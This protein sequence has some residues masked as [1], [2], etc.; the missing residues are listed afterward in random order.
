MP[1]IPRSYLP[2]AQFRPEKIYPLPEVRLP[3]RLN[4]ASLFL[5][6]HIVEGRGGKTAVIYRDKRGNDRALSFEELQRDANRL[7]NALRGLGVGKGDRVMLRAPNRPEYVVGAYACWRIGAM[8]VLVH[9]LLKADE[10]AFRAADSAAKAMLVSSDALAEVKA[11]AKSMPR[12]CRVIV[13]GERDEGLLFY[14]DLLAAHSEKAA[15]EETVQNDWGRIIYSSGTTGRPK[16]ILNTIGDLATAITVANTYLLQLTTDDVLGSHPSFAF[17]FGFFSILFAGLSG[18]TLSIVD[19]FD[20][21]FMFRTLQDHGITVLRCVPTVFRM[22]LAA[23]DAEKRYNLS[24]LRL[25]QSAGERLPAATAKEWH[26]R[27]GVHILDSIGSGEFHSILSTRP[28]TPDDKLDSSGFG[29]PG[30]EYKIV[31]EHFNTLPPGEPGE[32]WFRGPWGVQYWRRPELQKKS[33]RDGWSRTGLLFTQDEDGYFWLKGRDDDMI[34][35]AGYKIPAGEVEA[36]LLDHPEVLEAVVVPSPDEI[37]GSI[38]KAFVVTK[39]GDGSPQLADELKDFVKSKIEPYKYPREIVFADV[40]S[41]PRT[42]TGKVQRFVLRAQ[43][44]EKA[45]GK[46]GAGA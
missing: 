31:D 38:V 6:R 14:D 18:C 27:F 41:L 45:R 13:F 5:D 15:T 4:L 39:G 35:S 2:P 24:S 17:A 37:R 29:V 19:H 30:V 28:T 43:E 25:C 21:E 20:A 26:N 40:K 9:H 33:V 11:A 36:A 34:I 16:G 10:V 1:A 7:A 44:A 8:P 12:R 3:E 42:V 23:N 22:M 46:E 32:L